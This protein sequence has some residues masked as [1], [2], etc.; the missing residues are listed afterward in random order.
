MAVIVQRLMGQRYGD[1]F[2]PTVAGVAQSHNYYPFGR[3]RPEDGCAT[4]ALGLGKTVVDGGSALR[5]CPKH[6]QVLPQFSRVE[7]IL[8]HSQRFSY[9]LRMGGGHAPE[10]GKDDSNLVRRD[11]AEAGG[12]PP[13]LLAASTYIPEEDRIRDVAS[14]PGT[15]VITFA[16]ILKYRS[17]PLPE[18]LSDLLAAAEDGM[19]APVEIE[20]TADP[21]GSEKRPPSLAITQARP[22]TARADLVEVTVT[23][24]AVSRALCY[25]TQALG[26]AHRDDL[27]DILLVKRG[28]FDPARTPDM[29]REIGWLNT[30]LGSQHRPYILIGPGRW[31]SADRW[32]GIPVAWSDISE[33]AAIVETRITELK[34]EPSQ[35]AHFFHNVATLGISYLTITDSRDR[36]DWERLESL[37]LAEEGKF[38]AHLRMERPLT[39]MVDG[40][41]S[42]GVI[43]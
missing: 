4:I 25:S 9:A 20:F 8:R 26:N 12:E 29:A 35:G 31:G 1:L 7:D 6:P 2:Y 24:E 11:L 40:R 14:G 32:L 41:T 27:K 33:V 34:A 36:I 39:L 3:M 30:R 17:F 42:R 37:P 5:F 15:R 10:A 16:T 22:M 18:I 13:V 28:G 19:G 21:A 43:L 38:V 23:S